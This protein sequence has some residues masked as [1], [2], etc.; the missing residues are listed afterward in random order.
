MAKEF[1]I[2]S[3]FKAIDKF[4]GP[5]NKMTNKSEASFARME[6]KMNKVSASAFKTS[7]QS[8][9]VG[10]AIVA[11]LAIV[12]NEAVKF[13]KSMTNVATLID[14]NAES[15]EE[16]GDQVLE[17]STRLPVPIDELTES[18]FDVRSAGIDAGEA[19]DVLEKSAQL[20][21]AGL[22]STQEATNLMTSALNAF[23][24]E[25]LTA[26]ETADILFKTTKFGKTTIGEVSQAF[27]A[28]A[29][30][31]QSSG[32]SLADFSAATS[33]LTTVGTPAAQ[34]QNQLKAAI[35]SLQKP[36]KDMEKVFQDLGV[37]TDKELLQKFGGLGGGFEAINES[38]GRLGLNTAKTVGSTEALAAMTSLTGAT[39]EAYV[40]TL[41]AMVNGS[42][43]VDEAFK[44]QTQTGAAQMQMAQNNLKSLS[45]TL[46][47]AVIPIIVELVKA[48]TPM[49]KAFANWVKN[50]KGLVK[51]IVKVMAAVAGLSFAISAVSFVVGVGA[52]AVA[53]FT[54]V[55]KAWA[56]ATKIV[57]SLQLLWNMAMM[58]NPIGAIIVAVGVATVAV[59]ALAKAF[60]KTTAAERVNGEVRER[61]LDATIDQRVEISLLFDA[62]RRAKVGSDEYNSTLQK[63]EEI[64]PG[65]IKQYNLQAGALD[66]INRAEKEL[67]ESIMKRAE[68]EARA[69]L[70]REK[71][72]EKIELEQGEA[73]KGFFAQGLDLF[74]AGAASD[75]IAEG[76]RASALTDLDE[77]INLLVNQIAEDESGGAANPKLNPKKTQANRLDQ[78][79]TKKEE[80]VT[81]DF[82]NVPAGTEISGSEG[83]NFSVPAIGTTN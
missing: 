80:N 81:I 68:A 51:T 43:A 57:T 73:E 33:A 36:T 46:G 3:V 23:A 42:N 74:G 21:S 26:A 58:A 44:K 70:L 39:N 8:A 65:I 60:E 76:D 30:I 20:G 55:Q 48:V 22:A 78:S 79:I 59:L 18:L 82:K 16:M 54:K 77:D 64:Q 32:T 75:I 71:T 35:I 27:G 41:D 9:L 63:L 13:E 61:A 47:K 67:T 62:L 69:E 72:K 38:I 37:T 19:M 28:V 56:L 29:G 24:E 14:T 53:L 34:A 49:V 52:K 66:D 15:M 25:G 6:R 1:V 17:L 45:I 7:R 5:V 4:S 83:S 11:P 10:A 40:T 31:V 12:A 2:P 50:N